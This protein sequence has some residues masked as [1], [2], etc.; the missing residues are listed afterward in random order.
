MKSHEAS[1]SHTIYLAELSARSQG[2]LVDLEPA[3]AKHLRALRL[4]S[5]HPVRVTDGK[6]AMW[7][8]RLAGEDRHLGIQLTA[9]A[10]ASDPLPVEL[11]A[12]VGNKQA[13]LWL[14]E[15][16]TELG[17]SR[18]QP[19]ECDRSGSVADAGRSP[20]FWEKARRRAISA[21]KQSG[22]AWL[23]ELLQPAT[24]P[25]LLGSPGR[26][27][28][29][30][31]VLDRG[32]RPLRRLVEGPRGSDVVLLVGPE[33]GLSRAELEA[34]AGAGFQAATLGELVLRFETAAIAGLA[35]LAQERMV[36]LGDEGE[37][38]LA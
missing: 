22:G 15:K 28:C 6:G 13:M 33:G 5:G 19:V 35:V 23:P 8:A 30:R 3:E 10:A 32:G 14:V 7:G 26:D 36:N 34:C 11:W 9:P 20:A 16:A 37:R 29:I 18:I 1:G 25:D 17:V 31:V 2:D 27:G 38:S 12:P 21:L 24:L 4:A